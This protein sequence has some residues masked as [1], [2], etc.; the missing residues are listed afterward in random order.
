MRIKNI[1]TKKGFKH[2]I[3]K[4]VV[5]IGLLAIMQV[6]IQP[7]SAATPL[8]EIFKPFSLIYLEDTILFVFAIFA[9]YNWK[10]L[11]DI[12]KY[13]WRIS[14]LLFIPV[15]A[16]FIGAYYTLKFSLNTSQFWFE[17]VW[18]FIILKYS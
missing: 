4:S 2:L 17:H 6:L 11:V 3:I 5:F 18:A 8:P 9:A 10:N 7:L 15:G 13:K 12:K 16:F 1:L 14:D